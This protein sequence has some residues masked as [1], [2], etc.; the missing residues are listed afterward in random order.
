MREHKNV[1]IQTVTYRPVW[2]AVSAPDC[3]CNVY[4]QCVFTDVTQTKMT[5]LLTSQEKDAISLSVHCNLGKAL[6][7]TVWNV[8]SN[9]AADVETFSVEKALKTARI[10]EF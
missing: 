2:P 9:C 4:L 5:Y 3:K 7:S 1:I 10:K 8:T 6:K